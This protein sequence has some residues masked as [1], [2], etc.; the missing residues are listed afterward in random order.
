[1]QRSLRRALVPLAALALALPLAACGDGGGSGGSADGGEVE[2]MTAFY[3]LQYAVEQIGGDAVTVAS[4]VPAGTDP[5]SLELSPSQVASMSSAD[6][7]VYLGG[8]QPAVDDA[9]A[10]ADPTALDVADAARL[11]GEHAHAEGET[12]EEHADHAGSSDPHFWLDPLRMADTADAV[13]A[14]L[15]EAVPEQAET[16][17]AN[18]ADLRTRLEQLDTDYREGLASCEQSTIVVA[19]EAYG[20]LT[21]AYGLEQVGIAGIDPESE[22]SPARLREIERVIDERDVTVVFTE[23]LINPR[24]AQVLADDLGITTALLDPVENLTHPDS[25]YLAVMESNLATLRE[26]LRCA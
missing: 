15:A 21:E 1:M 17:E 5:H 26:A 7:V 6:L 9:V 18:A 20:Y 3:P 13:A 2:V 14:N 19:H 4:L 23:S 8:F 16:F 24:V 12:E 22:P 11:E 10:Q 25:D